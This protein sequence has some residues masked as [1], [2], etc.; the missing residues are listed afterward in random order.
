MYIDCFAYKNTNQLSSYQLFPLKKYEK[1]RGGASRQGARSPRECPP[2]MS[3]SPLANANIVTYRANTLTT[4]YIGR[5]PMLCAFGL[6]ARLSRNCGQSYN[7]YYI[8][9]ILTLVIPPLQVRTK[10][11]VSPFLRIGEKWNLHRVWLGFAREEE[12]NCL[13]IIMQLFIA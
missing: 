8:N 6:S 1:H 3:Y 2:T 4:L 13:G 10:L 7:T 12:G 11:D 5:C 9:H